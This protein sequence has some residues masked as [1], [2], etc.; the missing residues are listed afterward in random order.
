MTKLTRLEIE[1]K[2]LINDLVFQTI[3][4]LT[5]KQMEVLRAI[6]EGKNKKKIAVFITKRIKENPQNLHKIIRPLEFMRLVHHKCY[7]EEGEKI[8]LTNMGRMIANE[9]VRKV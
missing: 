2:L 9:I 5:I 4:G 7:S 8:K 6:Y 1:Q 3:S